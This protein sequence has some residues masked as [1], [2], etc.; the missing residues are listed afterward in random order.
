MRWRAPDQEVDQRGRGERLCKK[1]CQ[2]RN[3]NRDDAM[4][5]SRWNKLKRLEDDQHCGWVNVLVGLLAHHG[6]P[7][8]R[9][10]KRLL[11]LLLLLL[12]LLLTQISTW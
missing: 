5:R 10:V 12:W 9:A 6:S 11:L 8:Q 4:D 1:D 3:L 2:A 7:G